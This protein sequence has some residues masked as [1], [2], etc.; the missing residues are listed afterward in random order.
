MNGFTNFLKVNAKAIAGFVAGLLLNAITAVINHQVPWPKTLAEWGQYLG[1][2]LVAGIMV[3]LTG[4]KLTESQI[5]K[6]AVQQ[7]ITVVADNAINTVR[8]AA[9]EAVKD[10]LKP[11]GALPSGAANVVSNV[12]NQVSQ[13]VG[14]VLKGVANNFPNEL[15]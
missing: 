4:N 14:N 6:G 5:I 7:G 9:E 1:T 15:V 12:T 11:V 2:S 10:A 13:A 3:W 8:N